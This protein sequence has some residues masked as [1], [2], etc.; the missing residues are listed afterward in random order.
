MVFETMVKVAIPKMVAPTAT[1]LMVSMM[2]SFSIEGGF[3]YNLC[4][5]RE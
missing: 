1:K 2:E 4:F 5:Y 3:Y